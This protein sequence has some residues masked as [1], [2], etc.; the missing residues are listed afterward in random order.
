MSKR[1]LIAMMSLSACYAPSWELPPPP[2][3]CEVIASGGVE[4]RLGC[5]S[6]ELRGV[7]GGGRL[8]LWNPDERDTVWLTVWLSWKGQTLVGEIDHD[9]LKLG[10]SFSM[11]DGDGGT[12]TAGCGP[13]CTG[14]VGLE[15]DGAG[16]T[17][18]IDVDL[19]GYNVPATHL[20]VQL[21]PA[22]Q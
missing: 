13:E 14:Y 6:Q 3:T 2:A 18:T 11:A 16:F 12:S 22:Q 10:A 20:R 15:R 19:A 9:R 21:L 7:P 17:G 5:P 1:T 4:R 8:T